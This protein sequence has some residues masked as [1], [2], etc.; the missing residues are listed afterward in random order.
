MTHY[1]FEYNTIAA[2]YGSALALIK[3][4]RDGQKVEPSAACDAWLGANGY[5]TEAQRR[6]RLQK[7]RD[8]RAAKL[9]AEIARLRAERDKL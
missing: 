6:T 2:K 9:D 5:E 3:A 1:A 4:I 7:E 8:E